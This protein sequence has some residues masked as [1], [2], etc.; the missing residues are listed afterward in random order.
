MRWS[1]AL[2]AAGAAIVLA[3]VVDRGDGTDRPDAPVPAPT[4]QA[5]AAPAPEPCGTT[6]AAAPV[7]ARARR[8]PEA[9]TSS[10]LVAADAARRRGDLRAALAL[11]ED[12]VA[13]APGVETHAALGALY[14]E[15]GAAGMAEKSLRVAAEGDPANADRWIALAN[16]LAAKPDPMAAAGALARAREAEPALH[17]GRD[18]AGRLVRDP[19]PP[20]S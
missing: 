1:A 17:V 2:V 15:L 6:P 8:G 16:A 5:A 3:L 10:I 19:A 18:A 14:L 20:A 12:A 11:L 4:P 13:R 9:T 7:S